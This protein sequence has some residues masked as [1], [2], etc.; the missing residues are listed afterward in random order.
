LTGVLWSLAVPTA[1]A[2][3]LPASAGGVAPW[4]ARLRGAVRAV[5]LAWTAGMTLIL[6]VQSDLLYHDYGVTRSLVLQRYGA[7]GLPLPELAPLWLVP[8]E[9]VG[10]ASWAWLGATLV[11]GALLWNWGLDASTG[12]VGRY[13]APPAGESSSDPEKRPAIGGRHGNAGSPARPT[14]ARTGLL[15]ASCTFALAATAMVAHHVT[16]P[17][18]LLHVPHGYEEATIWIPESPPQRIWPGGRGVTVGGFGDAGAVLS[19]TGPVAAV[20]VEVAA[21][22]PME[23]VVQ[24]G[25][26]VASARLAADEATRIPLRPGPGHPWRGSR[27]HPLRVVTR[28]GTSPAA[29]GDPSDDRTVGVYLAVVEVRASR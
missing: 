13:R 15:A 12:R 26:D 6:M 3:V 2:L 22:A 4:R 24:L 21:F 11:V 9:P 28:G 8:G 17:V 23:V 27:F 20:V 10:V 19:T 18:S 14:P 29:L 25:N 16:V 7:P 1:V 5:L